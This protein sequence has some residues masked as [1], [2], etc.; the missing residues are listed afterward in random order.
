[1]FGRV[2]EG[3]PSS[4][5]TDNLAARAYLKSQGFTAIPLAGITLP[6]STGAVTAS[7]IKDLRNL[8]QPRN[9]SMVDL[10]AVV[11]PNWLSV[12][13]ETIWPAAGS[14]VDV[15]EWVTH[16]SAQVTI[17]GP[18]VG[19]GYPADGWLRIAATGYPTVLTG[20]TQFTLDATPAVMV[21]AGNFADA[22]LIAGKRVTFQVV[23]LR[24]GNGTP[25]VLGTAQHTSVTYALNFHERPL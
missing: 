17:A 8:A 11:H 9:A 25:G 21:A 12:H 7:V 10:P 16:A 3:V 5:I 20:W 4:A 13:G 22:H 2:L 1:M 24:S 14:T 23:G 15:P 6:A 18:I 19:T